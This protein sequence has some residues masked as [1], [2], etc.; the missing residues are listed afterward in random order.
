MS[1][2]PNIDRFN[3]TVLLVLAQLYEAFPVP[4]D[5]DTRALAMATVPE[6]AI[7]DDTFASFEP[8]YYTINFLVQEGYLTH[9]HGPIDVTSFFKARLTAKALVAMGSTPN[10]LTHSET[11]SARVG[12]VVKAGVRE[13]SAEMVKK[14][15]ELV[16]AS[17]PALVAAVKGLAA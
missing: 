2:P 13:A 17:A 8:A 3:R 11:V 6:G 9:L 7:F 16:F 10:A 4:V 5:V 1:T 14:T 15:V 12:A